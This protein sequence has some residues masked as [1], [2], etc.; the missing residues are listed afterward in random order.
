MLKKILIS[1][2][3]IMTLMAIGIVLY[4]VYLYNSFDI[5]FSE[6]YVELDREQS[7][8][9]PEDADESVD[10]FTVLILGIDELETDENTEDNFEVEK[11]RLEKEVDEDALENHGPEEKFNRTDTMILATFK[12]DTDEV[13]MVGISTLR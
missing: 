3:V 2:F 1:T 8:L 13:K 7:E 6:S 4:I 11:E 5:G 10:S 9:R 12:K